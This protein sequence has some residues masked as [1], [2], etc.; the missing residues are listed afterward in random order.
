MTTSVDLSGAPLLKTDGPIA[1][2]QLNRPR[3][4]NKIT[5]ADLAVL[6]G[7]FAGIEKA[8]AKVLIL[9]GEGRA[10]SAG[11]DLGDIAARTSSEEHVHVSGFD[12]VVDQLEALAIPSIC[13]LNGGVYGGATDLALACDFRIGVD[14]C[15]MFMPAARLGLHYYS[16]GLMRFASRLGVAATKKLF[17]TGLKLDA[18]EMLRIGYLDEA[19]P[20]GSLD[21]RVKELASVLA[22]NAPG[23]MRGMKRAINE[24]ARNSFDRAAADQRYRESLVGAEL[25]EGSAAFAEKRPP[26]FGA[27]LEG[28]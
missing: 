14:S 25:R 18:A 10:F 13:R 22:A 5:A 21:A 3:Q 24:I 4:M 11:Y 23:A 8:G 6:S 16:S 1:T 20:A 12:S 27:D 19:V 2:I 15:E 17:L 28:R 9:T 7:H 26:R